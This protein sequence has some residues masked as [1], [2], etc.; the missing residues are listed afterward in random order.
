MDEQKELIA[1]GHEAELFLKSKLGSY[2]R[3][4]SA[5]DVETAMQ[6]L[7]KTRPEDTEKI[8]HWQ[9]VIRANNSLMQWLDDAAFAGKVAYSEYLDAEE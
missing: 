7:V 4:R 1:L 5:I 8:R 6:N 3:E 9:S 2:I